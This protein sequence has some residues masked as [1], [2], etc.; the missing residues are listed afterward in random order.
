M[1]DYF[2]FYL[3]TIFVDKSTKGN[4]MADDLY[5]NFTFLIAKLNKVIQKIKT[6]EISKFGLHP[7]HV[8][9]VYYLGKNPQ[10]LT[11]KELCNL[12]LED[13]A[14]ISRALKEAQEKGFVKYAV[15]GRNEIV[16][17]TEEGEKLAARINERVNSAVRAG[18]LNIDNE[19]RNFLYDSLLKISNNL[20][21]YYQNL[22]KNEV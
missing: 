22:M 8:S 11:A 3:Y 17:L 15:N 1:L 6:F 7:I 5:V 10:G 21:D 12:S 2:L 16:Q 14:A 4:K 9:C 13:K 19:K 18:S 20:I